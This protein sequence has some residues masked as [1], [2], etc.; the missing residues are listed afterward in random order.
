[1]GHVSDI[2]KDLKGAVLISP[3]DISGATTTN[4]T[5]YVSMKGAKRGV[6]AIMGTLT[7]TKTLIAQLVNATDAGGTSKANVSGFTKTLTGAAAGAGLQLL[8]FIDFRVE[9]L[10]IDNAKIF[11][12]VDLT[13]NQ[14]G[15]GASAML[16]IDPSYK[17]DELNA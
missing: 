13:N 15:D 11:V 16:L 1:M 2:S 5:V 7:D 4:T 6:V 14:T 12:G 8:G 9:D 17:Y 3:L 10:D